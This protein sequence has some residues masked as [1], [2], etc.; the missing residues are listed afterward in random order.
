V[1]IPLSLKK[2]LTDDWEV[3]DSSEN[4][5]NLICLWNQY[6]LLRKIRST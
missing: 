5:S 1:D 4:Y 3:S 2:H 6:S